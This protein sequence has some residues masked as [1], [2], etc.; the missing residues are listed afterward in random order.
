MTQE[1]TAALPAGDGW[2]RLKHL[3]QEEQ[4]L[5]SRL[6]LCTAQKEQTEAQIA[7]VKMSKKRLLRTLS[8]DDSKDT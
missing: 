4:R 1:A 6:A 2:Q 5:K 3:E 8:P 7:A